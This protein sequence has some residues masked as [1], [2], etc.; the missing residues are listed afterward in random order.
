[1]VMEKSW[2]MKN[3]S[4]VME[5]CDQSWNFNNF[6]PEFYQICIFFVTNQAAIYKV[7]FPQNTANA[8]LGREMVRENQEMVTEKYFVKSV[9]TPLSYLSP[10]HTDFSGRTPLC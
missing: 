5:F 1:M 8:K 9:G 6:A 10:Q 4:K 2:N 3:W 7:H